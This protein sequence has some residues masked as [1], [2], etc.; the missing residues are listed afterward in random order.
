MLSDLPL[1]MQERITCSVAASVQFQIPANVLLA[2]AELENGKPG[3][4]V[5]NTNGTF[6]VGPMQFNTAYLAELAK[7]GIR[8][9]HAAATGCYPYRLAAWRLRQHIYKDSG[10]FWTRAANYHSRTPVYNTVYR[11]KLVRAA[12]R[13]A[14]W[15][16]AR[17]ATE[18]IYSSGSP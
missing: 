16:Q 15:L 8:P 4:V 3:Q 17:Y 12:R 7:Y 18:E 13:W 2:V 1:L 5:A 14:V 6:D 11:Q 9:A 10:D